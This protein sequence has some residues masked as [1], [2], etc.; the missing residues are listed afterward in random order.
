MMDIRTVKKLIEIVEAS[1]IAEIEIGDENGETI[2]IT[3]QNTA[4]MM[5]MM[6]PASQYHPA[7]FSA[8]N[9]APASP[10][11]A[12]PEVIAPDSGHKV[13]SPM[14]GTYYSSPSPDKPTFVKIGDQ[15]ALG[16]TLCIIEAMK[17]MN[18]I[19]ADKAGK[20]KAILVDNGQP[21]EY[22]Q[23]LFIIE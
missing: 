10:A 20:I 11:V 12:A 19:E 18:Q 4:P 8:P 1:N 14:V 15:V 7:S 2:R 21:V 16:Q 9:P 23:P 5:P 6:M 17:I 22:D 3:R 13:K